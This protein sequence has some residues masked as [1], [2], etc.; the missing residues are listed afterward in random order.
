VRMPVMDGLQATRNILHAATGLTRPRVLMLTTFDLD[1]YVYQALRAGAS[2]FLLKDAG[3][4]SEAKSYGP[5]RARL[6]SRRF[7]LF[8]GR[9]LLCLLALR[10]AASACFRL[11]LDR[12]QLQPLH[13]RAHVAFE[14]RVEK[15]G[16]ALEMDLAGHGEACP[17][18]DGLEAVEKP[19]VEAAVNFP[20]GDLV[21]KTGPAT[22]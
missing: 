15:L 8:L 1:D 17:P 14:K 4:R 2:G 9:V 11:G 16:E 20:Q 18:R 19:R 22:R 10:G 5:G 7:P 3:R 12:L 21:G 6:D 13:S